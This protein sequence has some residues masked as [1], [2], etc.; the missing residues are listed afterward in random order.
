LALNVKLASS[1]RKYL[2]K[3]DASRKRRI[4][5]RLRDLAENPLDIRLS[6]PLQQSSRRSSRVGDYRILFEIDGDD[7][8][9]ASIGPRG[10]IYRDA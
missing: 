1:A 4:T 8:I 9:V 5:Q 6:Y 3:L 2:E 7:L 10:Q